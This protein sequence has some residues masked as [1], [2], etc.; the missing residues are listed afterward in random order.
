MHDQTN[1]PAEKTQ[2]RKDTW[3]PLPVRYERRPQDCPKKAAR[4]PFSPHRLTLSVFSRRQRLSRTA[5]PSALKG[6]R[7]SSANFSAVI[8]TNTNGYAVV[9]SKKVSH[10]S[11]TRHR[12]KR[13]TLSA[14]RSLPSLPPSLILYPRAS[15]LNTGYDELRRELTELL[16]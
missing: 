10:L 16:S 14:L 15:A 1:V 7:L 5:F 11:V 9:V 2:T 12:I 3:L 4:R 8:P 13:R 6:R